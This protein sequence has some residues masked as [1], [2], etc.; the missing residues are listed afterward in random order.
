MLRRM[1]A[2][3]LLS[4]LAKASSSTSKGESTSRALPK[5]VRCRWPPLKVMPRSPTRVS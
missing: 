4:T 1:A 5:E 2:A 3:V